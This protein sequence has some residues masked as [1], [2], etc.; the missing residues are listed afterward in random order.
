MVDFLRKRLQVFVSSTYT[1]LRDERQSAVEAI[2]VAGHIPAGME[3]FSAGDQSQMDVIRAWI[4]ESDVYL[5]ILGGRY[6]SVD[7]TSGKSYI[8]LE[9]E[10]ALEQK[11]PVFSC[12]VKED[13]LEKRVKDRGTQALETE[14]P[15][16]LRAFRGLVLQKMVRFW[17]DHKDIKI[18]VG[19]TLSTLAR[20]EDLQGWVRPSRQVDAPLIADQLA[21][22]SK[23]NSQL[24]KFRTGAAASP[25]FE[26]MLVGSIDRLL[27]SKNL[28]DF[29]S[30]RGTALSTTGGLLIEDGEVVEALRE[31]G[32]IEPA[33]SPNHYVLTRYGDLTMS[34]LK[35]RKSS[36]AA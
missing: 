34:R 13:A 9:Y 32:V 3:L 27:Q 15:A 17:E 7:P 11:K 19:E 5:L 6:G 21:R 4:D 35:A 12:V 10:Y 14:N 1:D 20:R 30:A 8:H 23:E 25:V 31:A 2:L 36:G 29:L 24:R 22:L 28:I 26:D 18:A 33:N 16:K